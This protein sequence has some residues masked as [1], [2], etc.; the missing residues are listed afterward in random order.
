[1]KLHSGQ[2]WFEVECRV[3]TPRSTV[4]IVTSPSKTVAASNR[5]AHGRS[6]NSQS[7]AQDWWSY[8]NFLIDEVWKLS[9]LN[10]SGGSPKT[11]NFHCSITPSQHLQ[12]SLTTITVNAC[13]K[14]ALIAGEVVEDIFFQLTTRCHPAREPVSRSSRHAI[15][16]SRRELVVA[17]RKNNYLSRW[18]AWDL[19]SSWVGGPSPS[20]WASFSCLKPVRNIAISIESENLKVYDESYKLIHIPY[21]SVH[22]LEWRFFLFLN[23]I[24]KIIIF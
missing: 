23:P 20:W 1:M 17:V 6:S 5:L 10:R 9:G 16:T 14:A 4:W 2:L 13:H 11:F 7:T 12:S 15:F 8:F 18:F 21:E 3:V 22:C 24:D 19:L